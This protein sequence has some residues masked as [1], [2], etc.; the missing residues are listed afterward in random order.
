MSYR[1][2]PNKSQRTAYANAM[3]IAAQQFDFIQPHGAIRNGCAISWVDKSTATEFSGVVVHNSYGEL[4][5]Q[6]TFT[7][8]LDDGSTK[9][10]IMGRN[11]YARLTAHVQG[12]D[13]IEQSQEFI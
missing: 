10:R 2:K 1:W 13:S 11:L 7:V 5:G 4:T 8:L 9:K 6:H 12:A 3:N